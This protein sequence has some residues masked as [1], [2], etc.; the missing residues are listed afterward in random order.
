M[1]GT[2]DKIRYSLLLVTKC[3][4]EEII[5]TII[6]IIIIIIINN[7]NIIIINVI[8]ILPFIITYSRIVLFFTGCNSS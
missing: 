5:M 1:L 2:V 3:D 8:I 4:H 7:N 6:I